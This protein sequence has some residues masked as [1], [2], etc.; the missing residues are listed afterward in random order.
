M[1]QELGPEGSRS[2]PTPAREWKDKDNPDHPLAVE[3]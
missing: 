1:V 3:L 2:S